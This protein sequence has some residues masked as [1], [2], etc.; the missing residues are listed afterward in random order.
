VRLHFTSYFV[1]Q[2]SNALSPAI[3]RA[4]IKES[5]ANY[6]KCTFDINIIKALNATLQLSPQSIS[7]NEER[8]K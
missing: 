1:T 5:A 2:L 4:A 3:A 8:C 6:Y 7:Y